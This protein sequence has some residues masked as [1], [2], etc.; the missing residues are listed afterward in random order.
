MPPRMHFQPFPPLRSLLA[1]GRSAGVGDE[2]SAALVAAL[3]AQGPRENHRV[4][5]KER[6][7]ALILSPKCEAAAP[8]GN[9]LLALSWRQSSKTH[10]LSL[11]RNKTASPP[12][13]SSDS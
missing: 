11:S 13:A 4:R 10:S 2:T 3:G 8:H 7:A 9:G 6:G 1:Q 5:V 12:S